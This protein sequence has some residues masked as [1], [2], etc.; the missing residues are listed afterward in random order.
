MENNIIW[1]E[2][3]YYFWADVSYAVL[4][5]KNFMPTTIFNRR[6]TSLLR[7]LRLLMPRLRNYCKKLRLIR[8]A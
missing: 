5:G 6:K 2:F 3:F 1:E 4:V 8:N 7:R